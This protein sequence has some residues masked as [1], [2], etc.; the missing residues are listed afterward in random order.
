[1]YEIHEFIIFLTQLLT[2]HSLFQ[3]K[4]NSHEIKFQSPIQVQK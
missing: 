3:M 1:M 4:A 2:V